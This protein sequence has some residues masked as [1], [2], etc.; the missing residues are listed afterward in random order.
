MC[1]QSVILNPKHGNSILSA[2]WIGLQEL[3]NN[4]RKNILELGDTQN[5]SIEMRK[6]GMF[7][8]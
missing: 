5:N 7:G 4:R 1:V 2:L 6:C 8:K 3:E